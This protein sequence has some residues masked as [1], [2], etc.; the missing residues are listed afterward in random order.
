MAL[1]ATTLQHSTIIFLNPLPTRC[2]SINGMRSALNINLYRMVCGRFQTLNTARERDPTLLKQ[3]PS[4]FNSIGSRKIFSY[5]NKYIGNIDSDCLV[6]I[7][8]WNFEQRTFAV[9]AYIL[10]GF[11]LPVHSRHS[12]PQARQRF[13]YG[14]MNGS[15]VPCLPMK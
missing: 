3:T 4:I 6:V 1:Y 12:G 5:R 11:S 2:Q 9:E 7:A 13:N 14:W 10:S 8:Q 15:S